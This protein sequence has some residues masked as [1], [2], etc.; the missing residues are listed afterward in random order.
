MRL[1]SIEDA[2]GHI[3]VIITGI[4]A[5]VL[6]IRSIIKPGKDDKNDPQIIQGQAIPVEDPWAKDARESNKIL[7]QRLEKA[8]LRLANNDLPTDDI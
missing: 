5:V 4:G 3:A 8:L 6:A 2:L 1:E 7:T